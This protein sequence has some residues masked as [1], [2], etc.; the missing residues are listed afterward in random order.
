MT[1]PPFAK[2]DSILL[3]AGTGFLLICGAM[4]QPTRLLDVATAGTYTVTGTI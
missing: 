1:P 2:G 4:A 3:D